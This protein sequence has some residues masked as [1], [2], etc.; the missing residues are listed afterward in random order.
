MSEFNQEELDEKIMNEIR[1]K[2]ENLEIPESLSPEN[3][4]KRIQE[5]K[6]KK[7]RFNS[8]IRAI[9]TVLAASLVIVFGI[10]M[11]DKLISRPNVPGIS[12]SDKQNSNES[13][14][15]KIETELLPAFDSYEDLY[16]ALEDQ[17][18]RELI[19]GSVE[20][21][22]AINEEMSDA[23]PGSNE[24]PKGQDYGSANDEY[25]GTNLQ[26][27]GVDEADIIKTNGSEIFVYDWD[28]HVIRVIKADG[29]N[30][31]VVSVIDDGYRGSYDAEMYLYETK[32]VILRSG[33]YWDGETQVI[34]YDVSDVS[35]PREV[36]RVVQDGVMHS[37]R[38]VDGIVYVFTKMY[39]SYDLNDDNYIPKINNEK[40]EC[41][42]IYKCCGS[43]YDVYS[44][45]ASINVN[46]PDKVLDVK[47]VLVGNSYIYV[48]ED[49]I[50]ILSEAEEENG[51]YVDT[52]TSIFKI[53]YKDGKFKPVAE[54]MIEGKVKDQFSVDEYEGVLRVLT[55]S[56]RYRSYK[57]DDRFGIV[58]F[59]EDIMVTPNDTTNNVFVLDNKLKVI[60]KI[61]GL[62][63]GE[64]IYSAR[65][66]GDMG[67]FVTFRETD[68]VFAVDFTDKNNPKILGELKVSGFSEYLHMWSDNLM[69]GVGEEIDEQTGE[70]LGIKISMFDV[71]D[72]ENMVEVDKVVIE[73]QYSQVLYNHKALLVNPEKN[74]IGFDVDYDDF[75]DEGDTTY[76]NSYYIFSFY[77]E[78]GFIENAKKQYIYDYESGD[79][80]DVLRGVHI[81]KFVYIINTTKEVVVYDINSE[82][83]IS[84]VRF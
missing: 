43:Y 69:L 67:Y 22:G 60:G 28:M 6:A 26:V 61:N 2:S 56:Y 30:T 49:N 77:E 29:N 39:V 82:E 38:M 12:T 50:Y 25:T 51:I 78:V 70:Q 41:S 27:E 72:P 79:Y 59:V 20:A 74:L 81:G 5:K 66:D 58:D 7:N 37:S 13:K 57:Y 24:V 54:G 10:G 21:D 3:M 45:V 31:K 16:E 76:T 18:D 33:G 8:G 47:S 53:S 73:G 84:K 11:Y 83:I 75:W 34:T 4:M 40:I 80:Y 15:E 44:T 14:D 71:S 42:D 48:S 1:E 52:M 62:A 55:T 68:P 17:K 46:K 35:N 19:F 64:R 9:T 65:F 63:E 32:L 36:G 23:E